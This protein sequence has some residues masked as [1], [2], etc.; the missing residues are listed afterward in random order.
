MIVEISRAKVVRALFQ[1]EYD[2]RKELLEHVRKEGFSPVKV[3]A[4]NDNTK[5]VVVGEKED[6]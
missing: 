5:W 4:A 3:F 2:E 6:E 1:A